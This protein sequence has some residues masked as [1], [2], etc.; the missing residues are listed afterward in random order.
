ME[1]LAFGVFVFAVAGALAAA[2]KHFFAATSALRELTPI[3]LTAGRASPEAAWWGGTAFACM[4]VGFF[5]VGAHA[6]AV[7][8]KEARDGVLL[9]TGAMFLAFSAAWFSEQGRSLGHP[10]PS[11]QGTKIAAFGAL[12]LVGYLASLWA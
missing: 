6:L 3:A 1:H 9:G 2:A 12:F 8:S 7:G 5:T 10:H 11:R 4:N